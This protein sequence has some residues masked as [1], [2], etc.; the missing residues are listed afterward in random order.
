MIRRPP[1]STPLYSS[2]ASDVYKRQV[3]ICLSLFTPSFETVLRLRIVPRIKFIFLSIGWFE[4][5]LVVLRLDSM[6]RFGSL[7]QALE[8]INL[9][10]SLYCSLTLRLFSKLMMDPKST[11]RLL[12]EL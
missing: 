6:G 9:G 1:R 2:A 7:D 11:C 12:A 8:W 3:F 4:R 5:S 10:A